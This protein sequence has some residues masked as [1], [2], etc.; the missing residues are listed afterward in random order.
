MR[1]YGQVQNEVV[2]DGYGGVGGQKESDG[3][4]SLVVD[5]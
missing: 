1:G 5:V 3:S 4:I 2:D